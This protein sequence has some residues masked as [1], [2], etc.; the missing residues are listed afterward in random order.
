MIRRAAFLLAACALACPACS[1]S[2]SDKPAPADAEVAD[3][4]DQ[5]VG[6]TGD[7]GDVEQPVDVAEDVDDTTTTGDEDVDTP[8]EGPADVP[9]VEDTGP[10]DTGPQD[11]EEPDAAANCPSD[12]EG[13]IGG[14]CTLDGQFCA[15]PDCG[16][17]ETCVVLLCN[18]GVWEGLPTSPNP[19]CPDTADDPCANVGCAETPLCDVGCTAECGCCGCPKGE[20]TCITADGVP[21]VQSCS[22]LNCYNVSKCDASDVCVDGGPVAGTGCVQGMG[23]CEGVQAAYQWLISGDDKTCEDDTDCHML[24]GQCGSGLGGCYEAVTLDVTDAMLVA[25][26]KKYGAL[27]CISAVC[28]CGPPPPAVKCLDGKCTF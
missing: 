26:G 23:T 8:D 20:A 19:N 27:G 14:P 18:A 16:A 6:G 28:D 1:D 24:N 13:A 17:C 5:D 12:L 10:V 2:S 21:A 25:L 4:P 9:V 15:D 3:V 22:S 11:V 7:T